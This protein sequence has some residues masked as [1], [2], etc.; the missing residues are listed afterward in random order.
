M[1][2]KITIVFKKNKSLPVLEFVEI[3]NEAGESVNPEEFGGK[4]HQR[5]G[6]HCIDIPVPDTSAKC[7][8]K[9]TVKKPTNRYFYALASWSHKG[10]VKKVSLFTGTEGEHP[11]FFDI[12]MHVHKELSTLDGN[13]MVEYIHE[14]KSVQDYKQA[15]SVRAE[16]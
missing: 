11:S 4:S 7:I 5:D 9:K 8:A 3:E 1:S 2:K 13:V 15:C 10:V 16:G 14:F 12:Q 6:Y